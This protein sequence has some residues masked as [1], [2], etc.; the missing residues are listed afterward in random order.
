MVAERTN[1]LLVVEDEPSMREYLCE[2]LTRE[3]YEVNA[4]P[5]ALP[6][7]TY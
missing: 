2:V 4:F 7:L 5:G 6:A 3:G 1:S